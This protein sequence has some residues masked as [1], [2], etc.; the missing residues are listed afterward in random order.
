[1]RIKYQSYHKSLCFLV[2][3]SYSIGILYSTLDGGLHF[4][5]HLDDV[6]QGTYTHHYHDSKSDH[7]SLEHSHDI[8]LNN[9]DIAGTDQRKSTSKIANDK[10]QNKVLDLISKARLETFVN[11]NF[12][13]LDNKSN[14]HLIKAFPPPRIYS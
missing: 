14:V 5:L 2:L 13:Y 7:A 9:N 11:H 10:Y 12:S 3:L 1:M 6:V 4:L 8:I